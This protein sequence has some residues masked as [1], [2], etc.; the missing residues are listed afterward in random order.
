MPIAN[1]TIYCN[2]ELIVKQLHGE[3]T[4]KKVELVPYHKWAEELFAQFNEAKVLY[5]R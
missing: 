3:Y 1:L 5:F 4:V 2:S